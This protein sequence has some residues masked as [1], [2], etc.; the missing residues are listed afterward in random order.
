MIGRTLQYVKQQHPE[1]TQLYTE[2]L[3]IAYYYN[4][5]ESTMIH[6]FIGNLV[7]RYV[8]THQCATKKEAGKWVRNMV[9][10][11]NKDYTRINNDTWQLDLLTCYFVEMSDCYMFVFKY[12]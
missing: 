6:Y 2:D 11:L 1:G 9:N 12:E 8:I 7:D 5:S 10:A 4:N 3:N